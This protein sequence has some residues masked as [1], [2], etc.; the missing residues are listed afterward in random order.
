MIALESYLKL[1][2]L[3]GVFSESDLIDVTKHFISSANTQA[4]TAKFF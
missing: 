1:K 2:I 4:V 3:A